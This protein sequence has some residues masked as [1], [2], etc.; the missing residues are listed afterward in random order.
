L[1]TRTPNNFATAFS[2]VLLRERAAVMIVTDRTLE[3]SNRYALPPQ[4]MDQDH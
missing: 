1:T 3:F 4:R 2:A